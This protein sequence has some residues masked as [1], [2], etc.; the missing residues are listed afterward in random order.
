MTWA[1]PHVAQMVL[2][3][4][5]TSMLT[6]EPKVNATANS[7]IS[8]VPSNSLLVSTCQASLMNSSQSEVRKSSTL[9]H[10]SLSRFQKLWA[11]MMLLLQRPSY[12]SSN[13]TCLSSSFI[14]LERSYLLESANLAILLTLVPSRFGSYH[15]KEPMRSKLMLQLWLACG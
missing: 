3:T 13:I 8:V 12:L 11:S 15:S 4:S 9:S 10:S 7:N 5:L 6:K 2:F 1:S 14:N